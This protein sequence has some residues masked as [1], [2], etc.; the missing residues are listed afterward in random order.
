MLSLALTVIGLAL[1]LLVGLMSAEWRA[2]H[3][4]IVY[5]GHMFG[6]VLL[7]LGLYMLVLVAISATLDTYDASENLNGGW[8]CPSGGRRDLAIC[9]GYGANIFRQL[10]YR[11]DR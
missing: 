4:K 8:R 10:R 1:N 9:T 7:G 2:M 5:A 11:N 6:F 3:R